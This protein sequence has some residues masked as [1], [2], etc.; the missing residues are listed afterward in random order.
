MT[1]PNSLGF[2][3]TSAA[4][5]GALL[6]YG[7][8]ED[9]GSQIWADNFLNSGIFYNDI[10]QFIL[11]SQTATLTGGNAGGY[12]LAGGDVSITTGSL[13]VSNLYLEAD[14]SLTITATNLFTDTG[15]ANGGLW[16]VG[17]SSV[18]NGLKVLAAPPGAGGASYGNSLLGTTI[19]LFAPSNRVVQN[20]WAGT[21]FGA[22][23]AGFTNNLA[24]GMLVL[25]SQGLTN[26][27]Q[28]VFSGAAPNSA[29]YVDTLEFLD[30]AT[31]RD[32]LGNPAA[33][34]INSNLVIYYA[35][36]IMN[37][38]SVAQKLDGKNNGHLRWVPAYA[39]AFSSVTFIYNG[40]PY[41]FNA[42]LAQSSLYDSNANG[43]PNSTDPMP[44]FVS[45]MVNLMA[46]ATNNP[47]NSLA[48]T[49]NT[50]PFATNFVFYST[51]NAGPFSQQ[52]T[53][54]ISPQP[55][56]G[57]ATN[58]TIFDPMVTPPRYYRVMVYPWLTYPY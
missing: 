4:P 35:Q 56:T 53:N 38:V 33:L 36:A 13:M 12:I 52:L 47:P 10:G 5:Y 42:A 57:P 39:G 32:P 22:T 51:N 41:S 17:Q 46:Y 9:E 28:F 2:F 15:V 55:T 7:L 43:V 25:D 27:T 48:L 21:D 49:W 29:L 45:G 50:P 6:N 30:Q 44:F 14:R 58:V 37:G 26:N 11:H 8:I 40:V 24:V 18:G 34:T 23:P 31:I 20:I 16:Y 54:F 1:G 3:G 19:D